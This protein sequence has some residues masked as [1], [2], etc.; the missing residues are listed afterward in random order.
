MKLTLI[1]R[2]Y[3]DTAGYSAEAQAVFD[4]MAT[5]PNS[6]YKDAFATFIDGQVALS[7]WTNVKEFWLWAGDTEANSLKGWK[8]LKDSDFV[9]TPTWSTTGVTLNGTSQY[10]SS[11]LVPNTDVSGFDAK[12]SVGA[13]IKQNFSTTNDQS[14]F[15]S[16][17]SGGAGHMALNQNPSNAAIRLFAN[18]NSLFDVSEGANDDKYFDSETEYT[19]VQDAGTAKYYKDGLLI[20]SAARTNSGLSTVEILFGATLSNVTPFRHLNAKL[21]AGYVIDPT[22]FDYRA[23][24]LGLKT[25]LQTLG[26]YASTPE[27]TIPTGGEWFDFSQASLG[28]FD[29]L[30]GRKSALTAVASANA[31][32]IEVESGIGVRVASFDSSNSEAIDLASTFQTFYNGTLPSSFSILVTVKPIDGTPSSAQAILGHTNSTSI[33][34]FRVNTTGKTELGFKEPAQ[35][36]IKTLTDQVV[37][38]DT[39]TDFAV[40]IIEFLKDE[41]VMEVNGIR[42]DQTEDSWGTRALTDFVGG[43][44]NM[45]LGAENVDGTITNPFDGYIGDFMIRR[46][47]WSQ[48]QKERLL[49][50][51]S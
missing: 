41:M 14:L 15:G 47:A 5:E 16:V 3:R 50:Y 28:T 24:H 45:Y 25:M 31:P 18:T 22:G 12:L 34:Y 29:S 19:C 13:F 42:V 10:I 32:N 9:G 7:Q 40:I 46:G 26:V 39:P 11:N 6:T 51:F 49:E 36:A 30:A 38:A 27:L 20:N 35:A 4:L 1:D 2:F 37:F 44:I 33:M 17:P 23:F 48:S 43:S 21:A 8:G